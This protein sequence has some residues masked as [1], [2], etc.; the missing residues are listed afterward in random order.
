MNNVQKVNNSN[1]FTFDDKWRF[2]LFY[3]SD[4]EFAAIRA[5]KLEPVMR[6]IHLYTIACF[7][8]G[9]SITAR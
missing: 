2:F 6:R 3:I 4:S 7:F 1:S 5:H 8:S 9:F